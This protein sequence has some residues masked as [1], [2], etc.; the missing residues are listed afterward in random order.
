METHAEP[1]MADTHLH[2]RVNTVRKL[3][4]GCWI[5]LV[6]IAMVRA[7]FTRY[8]M[9]PDSM[10][11]L[12][13]ARAVAEG[14]PAAAIHA[15]WSP[16]YP[17]ILSFFFWLFRPNAYMEFPLV[18][19]ANF[20][21]FVG[22]LTSF[23]LFWKEALQL[24][25]EVAQLGGSEIPERALWALGYASF[26]IASLNVITV[27]RVGPDLLVSVFC[28][29]A[30][31]CTLRLRRVPDIGRA[32][33]LGVVLGLGYYV[34]APFFP[35]GIVFILCAFQW[36]LMSLRKALLLGTSV[37]AFLLVCAPFITTLSL[38]KGRLTFGDSARLN[39]AF[40]IDDVQF[41]RHW[42]G[43]PQGSGMPIHPTR[44]LSDYPEIFEFGTSH[45]GTYPPWFDPTYWN[46]GIRPHTVLKRQA[47]VL[48]RNLALEFQIIFES[49]AGLICAAII[50]AFL[51]GYRMW[52]KAFLHL[53]Y[54]W[55]PGAIAL[56]MFALV[57]VESRYLGGWLMII[58]AG[59]VFACSLQASLGTRR[60]VWCI[61]A[62]ALVITG[63]ALILQG[64]REAVG[65]EYSAGRSSRD[66]SIAIDLFRKGLH[67][68][69]RVALIGDGTSAYWAHL[70]RL[71]VVSEIPA[72][73]ASH[74][75]H[76]A[77]DF[78]QSDL[79]AQQKALTILQ[80]TGAKA[81]VAGWQQ[82]IEGS[83]PSVVPPPWERIDGTNAY[84]HFFSTN[85]TGRRSDNHES[86]Q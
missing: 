58:F 69:D 32:L 65:I 80:R 64:S 38:M 44:K 11:Y 14:Y 40:F 37:A 6:A 16:G 39:E 20:L 17:V 75:G 10:S 7:W 23:Q 77:L 30:G 53:W 1:S 71:Y 21:I 12:D 68:G 70:A 78:W 73:S 67:P 62:A 50:L 83:A 3:Q 19:L 15:Y 60:A 24:H 49:G 31:W 79:E 36:P 42:Q 84:V 26:G 56:T 76:P 22:A 61:S 5:G 9:T 34:K 4:I 13:I 52:A 47:V 74:R 33:L 51:T 55:G 48:L 82:S 81:V 35:L 27:G 66:A 8:E 41:F 54:V 45:M 43:G 46:A 28:C 86:I 29:L 2:L 59:V 25:K 85:T 72:A 63:A 18:H 57:R